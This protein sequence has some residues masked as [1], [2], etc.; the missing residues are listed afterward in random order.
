M[1]DTGIL[2]GTGIIEELTKTLGESGLDVSVDEDTGDIQLNSAIMFDTNS[3][4]VKN[5]G[6]E[7]IRKFLPIY[8]DVLMKPEYEEYV[9]VI[10]IEGY[11]DNKGTYLANL[12]L[13]QR[14][15][16]N[17]MQYCLQID[18]TDAQKEYLRKKITATGRS[19]ANLVYKENGKVD[20]AASRRVVFKFRLKDTK[21]LDELK[22]MLQETSK[23]STD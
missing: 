11:T 20:L 14:R 13:S 16:T 10:I 12:G 15:A 19:Y 23:E 4:E 5:E 8:L 18:L 6:Q 9:G 3:A 1:K 7:I 22:K 2:A 21:S 17:V